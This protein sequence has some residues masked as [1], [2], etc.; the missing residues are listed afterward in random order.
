[1]ADK[2]FALKNLTLIPTDGYSSIESDGTIEINSP[3]FVNLNADT[4]GVSTDITIGGQVS[5]D[6]IVGSGF[7]VGVG[8]TNPLSS[9]HVVGDIRTSRD[10]ISPGTLVSTGTTVVSSIAN[11]ADINII[12]IDGTSST[13]LTKGD[14][15]FSMKYMGSRSGNNNSFSIF[16]DNQVS[17]T[18]IEAITLQQDGSVGI[19]TTPT[20]KLDVNGSFKVAGLSTFTNG[21]VI[22][23]SGSSTGTSAQRL[24]VTGGAY[25]SGNLGI[26]TTNPTNTLTVVGSATFTDTRIQ[27]VAEKTTL[28]S[29]NTVGLAFTTGGG[30]VAIC[31][32]PTGNITLNVTSIPTDS[33][34]DNHSISFSVIVTQTGTARTCT[35]VNLNG[36]SKTIFW[37]GKSLSAAI[38][39][40]TTTNGYD[41]FTFTGINTV[42]S[43]STTTNYVIF[44]SVSGGFA[45]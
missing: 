10:L 15:G 16:S 41:I 2:N 37:S 22:V 18:Q 36:V 6:L 24:Q 7:Y 29:G 1:M 5:S 42:G 4:V 11:N 27:S 40:V 30:N 45:I 12:R 19:G 3:N 8:T 25:V 21:P 28:V 34:F 33:T 38:S 9:V 32:N 17:S 44:G 43:A 14:Y 23:G 35:A 39:G 20:T 13:Q 31:T 26:G